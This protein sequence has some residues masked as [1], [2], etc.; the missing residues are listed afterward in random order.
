M[1][2]IK[3]ENLK[4]NDGNQFIWKINGHCIDFDDYKC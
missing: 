3:L 1:L 4:F 2:E